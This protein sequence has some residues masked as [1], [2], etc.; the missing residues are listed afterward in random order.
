MRILRKFFWAFG[1]FLILIVVLSVPN[2]VIKGVVYDYDTGKPIPD[3]K[4]SVI[5]YEGDKLLDNYIENESIIY[6]SSSGHFSG[7]YNYDNIK[8]IGFEKEGYIYR[9]ESNENGELSDK[10]KFYLI[11]RKNPLNAEIFYFDE[12]IFNGSGGI[13]LNNGD[14]IN[15]TYDIVG[16]GVKEDLKISKNGKIFYSSGGLIYIDD[17]LYTFREIRFAFDSGYFLGNLDLNNG[18]YLIRTSD[19]RYG[20]ILIDAVDSVDEDK[21]NIRLTG[22]YVI[23]DD[24]L[25]VETV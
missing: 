19:G 20:K 12:H 22:E 18:V 7:F 5:S 25:N 21:F 1:I 2:K 24:G 16:E 10:N 8:L 11:R 4:V 3:V 14:V 17:N 15:I 23:S 9:L 6:T 13:V